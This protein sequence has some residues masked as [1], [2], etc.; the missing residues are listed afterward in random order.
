M[1]RYIDPNNNSAEATTPA[2]T[3]LDSYWLGPN[4][5][6]NAGASGGVDL[7][8]GGVE[9][10]VL[11]LLYARFWH[12]VLFDLGNV[13]SVEPFIIS[14]TLG[15]AIKVSNSINLPLLLTCFRSVE[16]MSMHLNT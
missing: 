1:L 3:A 2:A 4:H 5:N 9:H 16:S 11:H 10:A 15:S 13:S 12:K 7:Y 6:P 8:V 14:S